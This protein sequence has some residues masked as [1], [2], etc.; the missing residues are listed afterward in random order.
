MNTPIDL[1]YFKE[2]IGLLNRDIDHYA[3]SSGDLARTLVRL[4]VTAN[5]DEARKE[6]A[7]NKSLSVLLNFVEHYMLENGC[8]CDGGCRCGYIGLRTAVDQIRGRSDDF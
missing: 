1:N 5:E 3:Q 6:L 7:N 2:K 8:D 4:A